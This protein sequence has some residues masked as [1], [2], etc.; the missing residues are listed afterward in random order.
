[1]KRFVHVVLILTFSAFLFF[2]VFKANIF[3]YVGAGSAAL[4]SA[5]YSSLGIASEYYVGRAGRNILNSNQTST[6][7]DNITGINDGLYS[8]DYINAY[9]SSVGI[10]TP[11]DVN[12]ILDN[13][14]A[15]DF[16]NL[17]AQEA[18]QFA[19]LMTNDP[20]ANNGAYAFKAFTLGGITLYYA[21][22]QAGEWVGNSYSNI[23]A[24]FNSLTSSQSSD[25]VR[26]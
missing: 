17:S 8:S 14:K 6:N 16:S 13:A 18:A 26:R 12:Y 9:A 3:G 7:I 11:I 2:E 15:V 5:L 10:S 22:N 20:N 4:G 19:Q 23:V 21:L 24:R 25:I 1:M